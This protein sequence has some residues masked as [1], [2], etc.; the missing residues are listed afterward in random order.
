M[1]IVVTKE[2]RVWA[3]AAHLSLPFL[4]KGRKGDPASRWCWWRFLPDLRAAVK[5]ARDTPRVTQ[6]S[7]HLLRFLAE[8][9]A[10]LALK[11][12][13]GV[14]EIM[15]A[16]WFARMF[17]EEYVAWNHQ[18][19]GAATM[20]QAERCLLAD[21]VG[22]GKTLTAVAAFLWLR[23]KMKAEKCMVFTT[24][25]AK[26]QWRTEILAMCRGAR[27]VSEILGNRYTRMVGVQV[28]EGDKATRAYQ[29]QSDAPFLILNYDLVPR[30]PEL[31]EQAMS[32]RD[33][34]ILDEATKIKTRTSQT[35]KELRRMVKK[36]DVP[37]RFPLS[38]T[39]L[40]NRLDEVWA[41]QDFLDP[42]VLGS[43]SMFAS[44]HVIQDWMV[45]CGKCRQVSPKKLHRCPR[46]KR[47]RSGREMQFP[48]VTGSKDVKRLVG[49]IA[50][51]SIRRVASDLGWKKPTVS[52][53]LY[54]VDMSKEQ[55][56]RYKAEVTNGKGE[57][58]SKV[59][60]ATM[61][62]LAADMDLK[63][64]PSPKA[65][66][67]L[68]LLQE[69]LAHEK[70]LVFTQSKQFLLYLQAY[71][72]AKGVKGVDVIHGGVK[73][74]DREMIRQSFN[75][76]KTQVLIADAAAEHA[77]NLQGSN[78]VVNLDLPWNWARYWQRVGRVR[79]SLGGKGR[80]IRVVTILSK[81]TIEERMYETVTKKLGLFGRVWGDHGVDLTEVFNKAT[82]KEM[83]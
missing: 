29:Y 77:L 68:R 49:R 70:V 30:E 61:I 33:V 25:T 24:A 65:V 20:V 63:A 31:I 72:K 60:K 38:A 26:R 45:K 23:E 22:L 46:C 67:L 36:L 27:I 2:G 66:E 34:V 50:A 58:L 52:A 51:H 39:P 57:V 64:K 35:S 79:P 3:N 82:L 56:A 62:S 59:V 14:D 9:R 75:D 74:I 10:V 1:D 16:K 11:T 55:K 69:D 71:L 41:I 42:E 4:R 15:S 5:E 48:K 44:M 7:E 83:L 13:D 37:Y 17:T 81:G 43:Y 80:L 12:G 78:V 6:G 8:R 73:Q 28:I 18:R 21:D 32:E 76:G 40:E 47:S 19:T 53:P 54:W